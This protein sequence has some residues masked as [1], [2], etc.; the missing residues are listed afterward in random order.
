MAA[1]PAALRL[2]SDQAPF[3]A[4]LERLAARATVAGAWK[5]LV[6][7][8]ADPEKPPVR[9]STQQVP[10]VVKGLVPET[11]PRCSR[12]VAERM[13]AP[14]GIAEV[15]KETTAL[16]WRLAPS[17]PTSKAPAALAVALSEPPALEVSPDS[18]TQPSWA[19]MEVKVL[20]VGAARTICGASLPLLL[21]QPAAPGKVAV[22]TWLPA[23][24]VAMLKEAWPAPSTAMP[25]ARAVV[26]L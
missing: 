7:S 16:Y 24:S 25:E 18:S 21:A 26:P 10:W 5:S 4:A 6:W 1:R 13:V 15:S 2:P 19:A 11:A 9:T 12:R 3:A 22:T 14:S 17:S 23:A 8:A 20:T